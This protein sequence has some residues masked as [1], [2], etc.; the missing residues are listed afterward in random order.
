[1]G[2][3]KTPGAR[4]PVL[5]SYGTI[6]PADVVCSECGEVVYHG[7]KKKDSADATLPKSIY[8]CRC[9]YFSSSQLVLP[10]RQEEWAREVTR[11]IGGCAGESASDAA[12]PSTQSPACQYSVH[13]V[14]LKFPPIPPDQY[15]E[16]KESIRRYGQFDPIIITDDGQI[17]DG[18][19]RYQACLELGIA[20][21]TALF[22]ML[23]GAEKKKL[24]ETEFIFDAN[25]KRRHLTESQRAAIAAEFANMRQGDRTD[26]E[27]SDNCPKVS[28]QKAAELLKVSSKSVG[29]AKKVKEK[30]P[31]T[32]ARLKS[33]DVSLNA[34]VQSIEAPPESPVAEIN[35]LHSEI[36]QVEAVVEP[37]TNKK[38]KASV[39]PKE[40]SGPQEAW[41]KACTT[42]REAIQDLVDMQ[43]EYQGC[44][45]ELSERRQESARGEILSAICELDLE[46]ALST[47]E[48]AAEI[49]LPDR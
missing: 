21:K 2:K 20:P 41:N 39:R 8:A 23:D 47:I 5:E 46:G 45:E 37:H 17:L 14:A 27:P 19:H 3:T 7:S 25:M 35:R 18:R 32:F 26:L 43:T 1:M 13:P 10:L 6:R 11:S 12:A 29:R 40:T 16:L 15:A 48:E 33:G 38:V 9:A 22:S 42:A 34:A 31:A 44:Y 24:T 28:Q 36:S 30:D 49:D 4:H